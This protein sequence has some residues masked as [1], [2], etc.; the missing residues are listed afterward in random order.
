MRTNKRP[1]SSRVWLYKPDFYFHR[2]S[3]FWFGDD[4]YHWKTLVV[5]WNF[6]GQ[7]VIA[8]WPF[9]GC[10][11]EGCWEDL[12]WMETYPGWPVTMNDWPPPRPHPEQECGDPSDCYYHSEMWHTYNGCICAW[13]RA[14]TYAGVYPRKFN[15]K[16]P[17]PYH[18][19]INLH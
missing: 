5:G 19:N 10:D 17:V 2:W 11:E 4:E 8:L 13:E 1:F 6:T 3:P 18:G 16:C 15:R 14:G 9:T 7:I 12:P